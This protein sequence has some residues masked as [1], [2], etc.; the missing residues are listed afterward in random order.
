MPKKNWEKS[1]ELSAS[2]Y[3]KKVAASGA[4]PFEKM[5]I[6]GQG[7]FEGWRGENKAT[8]KDSYSFSIKVLS[9]AI[10]QAR[11]MGKKPFWIIDLVE[12]S[13]R[14]V[15]LQEQDF[16]DMANNLDAAYKELDL[17]EEQR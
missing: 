13:R 1:E 6:E 15:V 4:G 8:E 10:S 17:L 2:I 16:V 12:H 14:F 9:K 7:I 11:Q 5:D 3:G